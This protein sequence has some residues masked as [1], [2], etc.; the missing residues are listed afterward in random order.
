MDGLYR[1]YGLGILEGSGLVKGRVIR[2]VT[3]SVKELLTLLLFFH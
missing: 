2:Q 1:V 3:T